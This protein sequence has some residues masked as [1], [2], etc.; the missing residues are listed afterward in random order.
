MSMER[1]TSVEVGTDEPAIQIDHLVVR[2]GRKAAVDDLTLRVPRGS[3]FGLLGANGAGKTS[4]IETLLGFRPPSGGYARILGY[5]IAR[6]RVEINAPHDLPPWPVVSH[7]G[8]A[9]GRQA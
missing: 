4:T 9:G 2:Y 8:A 5:D 6:D 1:P 3:I 7:K